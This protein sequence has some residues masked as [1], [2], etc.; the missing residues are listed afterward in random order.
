[1]DKPNNYMMAPGLLDHYP[2]PSD[3][4]SMKLWSYNKDEIENI[5]IFKTKELK[6]PI[7][8]DNCGKYRISH[9]IVAQSKVSLAGN[10]SFLVDLPQRSSLFYREHPQYLNFTFKKLPVDIGC[11]TKKELKID[12]HKLCT[13]FHAF[14]L[15]DTY[16]SFSDHV[17]VKRVEFSTKIDGVMT[18]LDKC[19]HSLYKVLE[20]LEFVHDYSSSSSFILESPFFFRIRETLFPIGKMPNTY[21]TIYFDKPYPDV[22][23][24]LI[25]TLFYPTHLEISLFRSSFETKIIHLVGKNY[26]G[27]NI[28]CTSIS[29]GITELG[30][31]SIKLPFEHN[32]IDIIIKIKTKSPDDKIILT[33]VLKHNASVVAII[34]EHINEINL[35]KYTKSK[36]NNIYV[37]PF[38]L[39]KEQSMLSPCGFLNIDEGSELW[40]DISG[41]SRGKTNYDY[42]KLEIYAR[43]YDNVVFN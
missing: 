9:P 14:L 33:G 39:D 40:L 2:A 12:L 17:K 34:D 19:T 37:I 18:I 5:K 10:T 27:M 23:L 41:Y 32:I 25:P 20:K 6:E 31:T 36:L 29:D 35:T 4:H 1:M 3:A 21:L 11:C 13:T 42:L 38:S 15:A 43:R 16:L 28:P 24:T 7:D 26:F 8:V 30:L 22:K